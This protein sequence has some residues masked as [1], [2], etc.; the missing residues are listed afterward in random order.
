MSEI[1]TR[2]QL[3]HD[4]EENWN[5]VAD[6]LVPLAGEACITI[7]GENKGKVKYGDGV[8]KWGEL[9]Y[10]GGKDVIEVDASNV[11]FDDNLT[12]TYAFGKYSPDSTGQ[13]EVPSAGKTLEGLLL[14]AFAEEKNPTITQ[15]S[16]TVSSPQVKSYEVG[17]NVTPS[18]TAKLNPGAYQYDSS[19]G[20]TAKSWS[21]VF[22]GETLTSD[23]GTFKEFQVEDSTNLKITAT[24]TYD[25]GSI[26]HT[27]L[28]NT[29]PDGQIVAGSKSGST[30]AITGY[31]QFF[32]G[33][34]TTDGEINSALIRSLTSSNGAA[35]AKTININATE[36]ATRIII[37]LPVSSGLKVKSAIL[38]SS[39]NADITTSYV[40]QSPVDVEG[41]NGY[42]AA[43]Y[44]LY[45]YKPA[46]IDP[47]EV[48]SVVIGK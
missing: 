27:N 3:R 10:S 4:T 41:A 46:S 42:I 35:S 19:T 16:V 40:L 17:T 22:N 43:S 39:M 5:L 14:D 33:V 8:S 28:G 34:D 24:A 44:N 29:Y 11:S 47:T 2:I 30:S 38:T 13:I 48:H 15:P 25:A 12:F 21:V 36:G 18:Y 20:I 31:R 7:D 45:V 1:M 23:S 37:A 9:E 32:Y 26:P 6:T